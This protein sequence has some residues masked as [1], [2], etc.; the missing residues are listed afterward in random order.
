[1]DRK[2]E[3]TFRNHWY[4]MSNIARSISHGLRKWRQWSWGERW[5]AFQ[6]LAL[7]PL[8]A[9]AVRLFGYQ[10]VRACLAWT[11][12]N[13]PHS[14][15]NYGSEPGDVQQALT[16]GRLV[17]GAARRGLFRANCLSRSLVVW[18]LLGRRGIASEVVIGA[19]VEQSEF[20]A[21]A[22][23]ECQQQVVNDRPDIAEQFRPFAMP[24][25]L[26]RLA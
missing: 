6:A 7:L 18:R 20:R 13:L 9:L 23:V 15:G 17:N 22:W 14:E 12:P 21:H 3:R 4:P 10:R 26:R 8:V 11:L 19:Q 5:L 1:M 16:I 24:A 25:Q 2:D